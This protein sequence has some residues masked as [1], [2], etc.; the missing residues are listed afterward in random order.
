MATVLHRGLIVGART[1]A[2][3]PYG[4]HTLAQQLEQTATLLQDLKV[5]PT[6]AVTDLGY[7][8]V[9]KELAGVELI[10]RGKSKRLT[11]LQRRWLRKHQAIEP[12]VDHLKADHRASRCWLNGSDGDAL[13]SV[14]CA[15]GFNI[16]WLLRAIA[17]HGIKALRAS[18]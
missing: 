17:A 13:H 14:L 15:A 11:P 9:D 6:V 16:A 8:G 18:F 2:S 4:G 12:A 7:R 5:Q 3:N 1:F 10:H